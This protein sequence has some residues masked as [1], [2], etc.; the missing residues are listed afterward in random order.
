VNFSTSS[1]L[2]R[3]SLASCSEL[4]AM[5]TIRPFRRQLTLQ[6]REFFALLVQ[7][8]LVGHAGGATLAVSSGV[9]LDLAAAGLAE[10]PSAV[11]APVACEDQGAGDEERQAPAAVLRE[12]GTTSANPNGGGALA[13][14]IMPC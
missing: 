11:A 14:R 3:S 8:G 4:V 13:A 6:L 7:A 5:R 9:F 1:W 10:P 2:L 12:T